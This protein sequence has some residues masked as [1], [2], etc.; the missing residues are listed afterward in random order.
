MTSYDA[1]LF[2]VFD[3]LRRQ[4]VPLGM[5]EYMTAIKTLR[6]GIGLDSADHCKRLCR[7]LW[8]KSREDQEL[9]DVAFAEFAEPRL[10]TALEPASFKAPPDDTPSE[11]VPPP[12][13]EDTHTPAEKQPKTEPDIESKETPDEYEK[14]HT[15]LYSVPLGRPLTLEANLARESVAYHLTP[16]LPLGRREM[17]EAWRHLRKLQRV[18]PPEELDVE[19]TIND[20]CRTGIF[21]N[22]TLRPRRRNQA[23]LVLLIDQQGSMSPFTSLVKILVDSILRGG[24]LGRVSLYY[25]HDCPE[26]FLFERPSLT[27]LLSLE[28]VLSSQAKGN[29]VLIVSDAGAARGYYDKQRLKDTKA[30]LKTLNAFT[31]LYAWLNPMPATRWRV[32]TAE[33]IARLAPMFHLDRDGLNDT[34]NILR[35]HPFPPEVNLDA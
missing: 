9:F 21:L 31:Y 30:F 34:V 6:E 24:L 14:E 17:A 18:G 11:Y 28:Q 19:S 35:G 3:Y 32:T 13:L 1:L 16:R 25:F 4:G 29:S 10:Q 15:S 12:T 27:D 26:G 33:D 5:S 8:A 20:I 22:P 2:P 7:L 23:R